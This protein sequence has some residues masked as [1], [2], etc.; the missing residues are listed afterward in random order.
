M[1]D[2]DGVL[3]FKIDDTY[4]AITVPSVWYNDTTA[5]QISY[6]EVMQE[7]VTATRNEWEILIDGFYVPI[8]F[9]DEHGNQVGKADATGK[10]Q[11][12]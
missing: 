5:S 7:L 8:A 3:D 2:L 1:T 4:V 6:C 10:I 11:V 9:Y 12:K